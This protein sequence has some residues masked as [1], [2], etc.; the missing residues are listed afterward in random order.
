MKYVGNIIKYTFTFIVTVMTL[1][2]AIIPILVLNKPTTTTDE[3]AAPTKTTLIPIVR[4]YLF[5]RYPLPNEARLDFSVIEL[6]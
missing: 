1:A 5:K 6:N 2:A 3:I 4:K